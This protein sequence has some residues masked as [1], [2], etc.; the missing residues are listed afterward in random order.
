MSA[1]APWTGIAPRLRRYGARI[2]LVILMLSPS[3]LYLSKLPDYGRC[4]YN[5]YYGILMVLMDGNRVTRNPVRWL[6]LKSN[7]HTVTLPALV[8]VAN[9]VLTHGD[10]RGLSAFAL[11]LLFLTWAVLYR[12]AARTLDL[13]PPGRWLAGFVLAAFVFSP[14]PAHSVVLG[15]SGTIWFMSNMFTVAAFGLL[16]R[17]TGEKP[18]SIAPVVLAGFLGA[19]SY[20]TN[21]SLW[22]ALIVAALLLRRPLRHLVAVAVTGAAV[23]VVFFHFFRPLPWH[24]KLETSHPLVLLGYTFT[25]LGNLFSAHA[26]RAAVIGGIGATACVFMAGRTILSRSKEL[27]RCTAPW[28]GLQVYVLGNAVGTAVGR[29]GFGLGQAL[30]SRYSS[31]SALF[32]VAELALLTVMLVPVVRL[33]EGGRRR[34]PAS[35]P[36][37]AAGLLLTLMYHHGLAVYRA[38]LGRAARQPMAA[39]AVRRGIPDMEILRVLTP[40]PEQI[41]PVWRFL[42]S[43]GQVPFDQPE[44]PLPTAPISI[45]RTDRTGSAVQGHF[46]ALVRVEDH[47]WR[48]WGWAFA[49]GQRIREVFLVDEQGVA[50]ARMV[51]SLPR[52]GVAKVVGRGALMSG[53]GGYVTVEDSEPFPDVAVVL[54]DGMAVLLH[55]TPQVIKDDAAQ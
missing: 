37:V 26:A 11:F 27:Q 38:Y 17:E 51:L 20:S 23:Y 30:S 55:G 2:G 14:V 43:H 10:N 33:R 44:P 36:L 50:V 45:E 5:D 7:E 32:W 12:L 41:R 54:G 3:L 18:P 48:A 21:L 29:S 22:P 52:P 15:F 49:G 9:T 16:L 19:L 53:W 46:D 40:A 4:Q 13:P 35:V 6:K 39:E 24:P 34:L 1:S 25:Y 47:T 8:Y 28:I 31:L 42:K